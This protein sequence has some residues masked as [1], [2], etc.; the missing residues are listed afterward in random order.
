[1]VT[2]SRFYAGMVATNNIAYGTAQYLLPRDARDPKS[3]L[4]LKLLIPCRPLGLR[5][6]AIRTPGLVSGVVEKRKQTYTIQPTSRQSIKH[7]EQ[8][9]AVM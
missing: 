8:T 6:E 7:P 5:V 2:Y 9:G 1:M 4:G 3:R